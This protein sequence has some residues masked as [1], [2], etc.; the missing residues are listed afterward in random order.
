MNLFHCRDDG[1]DVVK[2][3]LLNHFLRYHFYA[4]QWAA[5][6]SRVE[7]GVKRVHE[8]ILDIADFH[9]YQVTLAVRLKG[10]LVRINPPFNEVSRTEEEQRLL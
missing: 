3:H 1:L 9:A 4:T 8:C 2:V 6:G 5:G 10:L 7:D